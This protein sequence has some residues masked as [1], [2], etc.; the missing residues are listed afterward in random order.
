MAAMSL[1]EFATTL[2]VARRVVPSWVA[3]GLVPRRRRRGP[4]A[5]DDEATVRRVGAAP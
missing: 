1:G 3:R 5:R 2:G 4:R